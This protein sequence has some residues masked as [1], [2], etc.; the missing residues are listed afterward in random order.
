H[1]PESGC[2]G[3]KPAPGLITDLA[4]AQ[5]LDLSRAWYVGDTLADRECARRA[6]VGQFYWAQTFFAPGWALGV[7]RWA[8]D[9]PC[10]TPNAQRPTPLLRRASEADLPGIVRIYN[11]AIEERISTCDLEPVT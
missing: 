4:A 2:P 8:L 10:L 1:P 9:Q 11:E 3:H 7:G 6:G 5:G